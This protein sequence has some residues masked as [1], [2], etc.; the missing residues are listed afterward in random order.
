[1]AF[2]EMFL[3]GV[4]FC[5]TQQ[6]AVTRQSPGAALGA[7]LTGLGLSSRLVSSACITPFIGQPASR[8]HQ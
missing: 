4:L 8:R 5:N 6:R 1:M 7:W 2:V 3:A